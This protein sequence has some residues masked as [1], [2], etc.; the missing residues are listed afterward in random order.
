MRTVF[1]CVLRSVFTQLY[2]YIDILYNY[3]YRT[4]TIGG[5]EKETEE[6]RKDEFYLNLR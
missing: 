6:R 2:I 4:Y 3:I 5:G 1:S